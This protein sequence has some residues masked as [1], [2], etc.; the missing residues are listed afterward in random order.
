MRSEKIGFGREKPVRTQFFRIFF[1]QLLR[2]GQGWEKIFQLFSP[3]P[4]MNNPSN[5]F[6]PTPARPDP[7]LLLGARMTELRARL[8]GIPPADL[9]ARTGSEFASQE[10]RLLLWGQPICLTFPGFIALDAATR[11]ELRPDQQILLL[12]YYATADGRP[13]TGQWVSF[14]DLPDGRFY[15]QAFQGY[16]GHELARAFGPDQAA[17]ETA[18]SSLDGRPYPLGEAAFIFR[19]L[20]RLALLVSYWQGDEDFSPSCQ[21][22]FDATAS[23]YLPTDVCAILGS[24]LTRRLI[25]A[26]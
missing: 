3:F 18:A 6:P 11:Q 5:K 25:K 7:A 21:I 15:N 16:T 17:F 14:A 22:L 8:E 12:Y 13:E 10:F 23:H 24:S 9:A 19:A 1:P 4:I 26:K 2:K 20:P